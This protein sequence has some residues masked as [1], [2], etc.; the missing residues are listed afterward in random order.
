LGLAR[1]CKNCQRRCYHYGKNYTARTPSA[2]AHQLAR[3]VQK[4]HDLR[5]T[6]HDQMRTPSRRAIGETKS[7]WAQMQ[8]LRRRPTLHRCERAGRK[9]TNRKDENPYVMRL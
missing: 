6:T 4:P 5:E 9:P 2:P 1:S 7:D 3:T 8:T